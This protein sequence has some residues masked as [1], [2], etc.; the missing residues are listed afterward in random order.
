MSY[1]L[2]FSPGACSLSVN[3][4]LREAGLPFELARVDLRQKKLASGE[5]YRAIN[6]NGYVPALR[7]ADGSV[8]TEAAVMVQY[9][10]DQKPE[11]RLAP[12]TGTMERYRFQELLNF[13]ATELHKGSNP[14]YS[15]VANDDY[16]AQ[17]KER[18]ASRWQYLESRLR[19][20]FL[21]GHFT[22]ADSYAFYVLRAWQRAHRE[23]L[24]RWPALADYYAR[25]ASR[26][27]VAAALASEGLEP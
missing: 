5:D 21:A 17:L 6:P 11:A 16:K 25:L 23:D 4:V 8:L 18:L 14:L 3:I 13:I 15:P 22:A 24:A 9:V 20:G 27:T 1:V 2:Y 12:A 10:A 26:P 19:D 7:L